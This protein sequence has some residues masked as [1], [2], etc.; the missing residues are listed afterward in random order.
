MGTQPLVIPTL[1]ENTKF[2]SVEECLKNLLKDQEEAIAAHE[3][4]QV[5]MIT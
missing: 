2:P 1:F 4:A 5:R 3:L